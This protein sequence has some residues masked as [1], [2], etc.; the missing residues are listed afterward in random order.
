ML[1]VQWLILEAKYLADL[2]KLV[3]GLKQ[4]AKSDPMV[5]CIIE[6][7]REHII[8]GVGEVHPEILLK[9]L[10]EDHACIPIKK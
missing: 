3:E 1:S 9:G 2:L 5:Q 6:E 10:K 7:S 8:P 4:L